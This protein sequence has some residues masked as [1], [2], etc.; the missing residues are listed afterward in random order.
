LNVIESSGLGVSYG[1]TWALRDCTLSVPSGRIVALVGSNGA[2]KT[3]LLHCL[4]GLCKPTTGEISVLEGVAP[5]SAPARKRIAFVAQDAPLYRHLPVRKM[6]AVTGEL[7]S[8]FDEEEAASR[9]RSLG[10]RLDRRVGNLSGG[11]H[12]QLAMTLALARHPDLLVL[13]EPLAKLDPV[14]RHDVMELIVSHVAEGN[15]SVVFSSHVVSEL[16]LV[17]DYL[18]LLA[19]GRV[20]M[21]DHIDRLLSQH[22]VI[23]APSSVADDLVRTFSVIAMQHSSGRTHLLVRAPVSRELASDWE[24]SEASLDEIV[25][26]Y[27]RNPSAYAAPDPLTVTVTGQPGP[28][29]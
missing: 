3:T 18:I 14:A 26:A 28:A 24:L 15:L 21:A 6:L 9:L 13:D 29:T 12:A 23:N 2:G 22:V 20:L 1:E 5:G 27:L 11:Q 25:L 17:A 19:D 16:E 10:V 4:V 8:R 7:N